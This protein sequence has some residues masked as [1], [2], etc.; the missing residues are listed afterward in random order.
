MAKPNPA[1][2]KKEGEELKALFAKIKKKPHN[3]AILVAKDG[4]VIEAHIKKSPEILVKLAK[5]R[6]GTAKGAWGTITMDG[7]VLTLD[8]I[9]DK[10]PGNLPKLCKSYFAARGLKNR[11]EIKEPVTDTSSTT[12]SDSP[13]GTA[14]KAGELKAKLAK[15]Q[16]SIDLLHKN[17]DDMSLMNSENRAALT[18][19]FTHEKALK[20]ILARLEGGTATDKDASAGEETLK[21]IDPMVQTLIQQLHEM[22]DKL[23]KLKDKVNKDSKLIEAYGKRY[24]G[25]SASIF[26]VKGS[27]SD[28]EARY[29][30]AEKD[31]KNL[32][33]AEKSYKAAI[34]NL[35]AGAITDAEKSTIE[36]LLGLMEVLSKKLYDQYSA[37]L[38]AKNKRARDH[39][40]GLKKAKEFKAK[41]A[42]LKASL[43]FVEKHSEAISNYSDDLKEKV[44]T[45]ENWTL[46]TNVALDLMA[47]GTASEDDIITAEVGL[48][49]LVPLLEELVL[50]A[51]EIKA[52]NDDLN[53]DADPDDKQK[54]TMAQWLKHEKQDINMV[55]KDK[56]SKHN[57]NMV[58]WL[59]A[60]QKSLKAEKL[61]D[62]QQ[63]LDEV[64]LVLKAYA[65]DFKL[66]E[67]QRKGM[68]DEIRKMTDDLL[69]HADD[70]AKSA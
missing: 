43:A 60:Y 5:K 39:K 64:A 25:V 58:K 22:E 10:V 34:D 18:K 1:Q 40:E 51:R 50:A 54:K 61:D 13:P 52:E 38:A 21:L 26:M 57:K 48:E 65:K 42:K 46:K 15:L 24:D 45:L 35:T 53:N 59:T 19:L 49:K 14:D 44:D 69:K 28:L 16:P 67:K 62:A 29:D 8:P 63:A 31:L 68:M 20:E 6:G 23:S 4:V 33:E 2:L 3:C 27:E 9:N 47:E 7:Q 11:L 66:S 30:S 32:Y 70:L 37:M 56:A 41:M 55:L 12:A 17:S 36:K